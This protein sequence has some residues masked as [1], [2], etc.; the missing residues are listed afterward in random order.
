MLD[1]GTIEEYTGVMDRSHDA[2]GSHSLAARNEQTLQKIW[3]FG[4]FVQIKADEPALSKNQI[5]VSGVVR[6][7][8]QLLVGKYVVWVSFIVGKGS[9]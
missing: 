9:W 1:W 5:Q 8:K 2:A 3:F 6:I 4:F 7:R